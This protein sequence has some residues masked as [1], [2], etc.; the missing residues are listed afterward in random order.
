MK[1]LDSAAI[2]TML[3]SQGIALA[4]G[5]AERLAPGV[6]ALN[7]EDPLR[8]EMPFEVDATTYLSV[9]KRVQA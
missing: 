2:E 3:A 8:G 1:N 9:A 4:A 6:N 7:V 5:R